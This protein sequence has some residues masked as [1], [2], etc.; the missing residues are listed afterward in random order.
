MRITVR[1]RP[2]ASRAKVGGRWGEGDVLGVAVTARAVDGAAT[3]AALD[4]I[5]DAF[6]VRRRTVRL[7]TGASARTKV[8]ELTEPPT[9][10]ERRLEELLGPLR[11]A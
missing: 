6:S 2:G 8:V 7:I 4:A 3:Q 1:V 10:A 9:D 11:G 5:A